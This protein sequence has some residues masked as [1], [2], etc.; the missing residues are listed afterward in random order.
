MPR[1]IAEMREDL[2]RR[3][4]KREFVILHVNRFYGGFPDKP[5]FYFTDEKRPEDYR[6]EKGNADVHAHL[7][8]KAKILENHGFIVDIRRTSVPYY[9][10]TEDFVRLLI[11]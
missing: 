1:L 10:M 3:P 6:D 7:A 2:K 8:D 9:R 11:A 4:M 5:L